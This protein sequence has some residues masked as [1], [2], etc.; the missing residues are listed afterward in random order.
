MAFRA[1]R[2]TVAEIDERHRAPVGTTGDDLGDTPVGSDRSSRR[3]FLTRAAAGG[4]IAVGAS[5][6]PLSSIALAQ[7]E[8]GETSGTT[9]GSTPG[10][11]AA[12][13]P[14]VGDPPV[15]Q[16]NDLALVVFLQSLELAAVK[17]Y[18]NLVATG[19]I[20]PANAQT[21]REFSLHHGEHGKALAELAGGAAATAP[22]PRLNTELTEAIT[23]GADQAQLITVVYSLEES[24]T[25]TYAAALGVFDSWQA[26]AEA[27]KI[28]PID[29]QHAVV[30][31]QVLVPDPTQWATQI[32]TWIPNFQSATGA[33]DFAG[34]PAS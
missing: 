9:P 4:A 14:V 17:A 13:A 19:R 32:T 25:A 31:S 11:T 34:Y 29:S 3:R 24:L 7:S 30:W 12:A 15:V 1:L 26:A 33:I 16:G 28:L 22:N 8:D 18:E 10:T 5:A 21:A 23:A 27:S 6:L 2:R 20:A